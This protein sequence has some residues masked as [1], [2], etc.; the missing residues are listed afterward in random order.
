M[1]G[2]SELSPEGNFCV[3][4]EWSQNCIST[5]A[6]GIGPCP[7]PPWLSRPANWLPYILLIFP[8]PTVLFPFPSRPRNAHDFL[9]VS[10]SPSLPPSRVDLIVDH[11]PLVSLSVFL[12]V[13]SQPLHDR[14]LPLWMSILSCSR[15]PNPLFPSF[16]F[17]LSRPPLE[18]CA[19]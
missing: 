7:C 6:V 1:P 12:F 8:L 17:I 5:D 19:Q 9:S 18:P 11:A 15:I 10:S 16:D 4:V 3:A 2:I 13:S 14:P